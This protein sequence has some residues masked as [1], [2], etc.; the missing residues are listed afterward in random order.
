MGKIGY[1]PIKG[2]PESPESPTVKNDGSPLSPIR[3]GL[4]P[5]KVAGGKKKKGKKGQTTT[6]KGAGKK[7]DNQDLGS[8]DSFRSDDDGTQIR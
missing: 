2:G 4:Q 3:D 1:S 7:G 5:I 8:V 6:K